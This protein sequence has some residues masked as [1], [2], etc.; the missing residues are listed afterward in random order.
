[1]QGDAFQRVQ[2]SFCFC[3][4]G[5]TVTRITCCSSW[6]FDIK[7]S[8]IV[9]QTH[10]GSDHQSPSWSRRILAI[11]Q[12]TC[13]V[14]SAGCPYVWLLLRKHWHTTQWPCFRSFHFVR[15]ES[16]TAES[17]P[18]LQE[19]HLKQINLRQYMIDRKSTS[20]RVDRRNTQWVPQ[21]H[22]PLPEPRSKAAKGWANMA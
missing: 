6:R 20:R 19:F 21:M 14:F 17:V 16:G 3:Y 9:T 13:F 8:I 12:L 5:I 4:E 7:G 18:R 10:A 1:M 11:R 15:W 2:S 22:K